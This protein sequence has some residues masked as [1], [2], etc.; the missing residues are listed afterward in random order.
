M[1]RKKVKM[2]TAWSYSRLSDYE[3]CPLMAKLKYLD[4]LSEPLNKAMERGS[5]IHK[6]AEY[7]VKGKLKKLPGSLELFDVE[8]EE[9]RKL[10]MTRKVRTELEI[11]LDDTFTECGWFGED[12]WVRVKADV[13]YEGDDVWTIIDHKTGKVQ[14]SHKDQ[15]SLYAL[16]AF[17]MAPDGMENV[18]AELW[19]LDEGEVVKTCYSIGDVPKLKKEWTRRSKQMMSA[20]VFQPKQCYKCK[21]CPFSHSSNSEHAGLCKY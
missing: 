3:S 17:A 11:G 20:K 4:K 18:E 2:F 5:R 16:G 8:F 7:Y 12:T 19:Y 9:L 10:Y 21:W 6:E 15:L 13:L 14:D 1:P